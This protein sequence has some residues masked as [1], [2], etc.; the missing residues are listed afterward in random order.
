MDLESTVICPTCSELRRACAW[1]SS[2]ACSSMAAMS[3][4]RRTSLCHQ[5]AVVMLCLLIL[6]GL[7]P[8]ASRASSLR[9]SARFTGGHFSRKPNGLNVN[10]R[11]LSHNSNRV[12]KPTNAMSKIIL[13][14]ATV[15]SGFATELVSSTR[16]ADKPQLSNNQRQPTTTTTAVTSTASNIKKRFKRC[17]R[18]RVTVTVSAPG[19]QSKKVEVYKCNGLCKSRS[20]AVA[21]PADESITSIDQLFKKKCKC[22][23]ATRVRRRNI[24]VLL[25]C[26]WE[27]SFRTVEVASA[28]ECGCETCKHWLALSHAKHGAYLKNLLICGNYLCEYLLPTKLLYALNNIIV[29]SWNSITTNTKYSIHLCYYLQI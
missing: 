16:P 5:P 27:Q 12:R 3:R 23:K 13:V 26:G 4:A 29:S 24:H 11:N 19:C 15:V 7:V 10:V 25:N 18:H 1:K 22:C 17:R 2:S 20:D 9:R 14:P 21:V 8:D 6:V 28:L